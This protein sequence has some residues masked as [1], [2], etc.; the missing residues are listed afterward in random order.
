MA[1]RSIEELAGRRVF[2]GEPL[3]TVEEFI[4]GD[5]VYVDDGLIRAARF[6]RVEVDMA[7]RRIS[8]KPF[9]AKPRLP[10]RGSAVYGIVY[11]VP[12]EELALVRIFADERMVPYNGFFSGAL[13]IVQVAD[14]PG[15]RSIYDY[16]KPGDYIRA[17]VMSSTPPFMLSMKKSQDG[18]VLAYCS[19]C[20]APLYR[21]PGSPRLVCLHCG[22]EEDRRVSPLY[23]LTARRKRRHNAGA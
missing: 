13:H 21:V 16:V 5:G 3:C 20:G 10:R 14:S 15:E 7:S 19:V 17:T 18:V 12:R 4:P 8:V 23:I 11:A 1:L 6:G 22:N 9:S 2:P